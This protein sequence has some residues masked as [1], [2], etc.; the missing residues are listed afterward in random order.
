MVTRTRWWRV[1]LLATVLVA[2][3]TVIWASQRE[4]TGEESPVSSAARTPA[5]T[6]EAA[7]VEPSGVLGAISSLEKRVDQIA[8]VCVDWGA[9]VLF[10]D[11]IGRARFTKSGP[12]VI[13]DSEQIHQWVAEAQESGLSLEE[14]NFTL[15]LPFESLDEAGVKALQKELT[16]R[17]YAGGPQRSKNATR[18]FSVKVA[19]QTKSD[20]GAQTTTFTAVEAG[21]PIVVLWLVIGSM[22]FTVRMGFINIRGF[23]HAILV[24][25]GRYD[26]PGD[27]GEV[28]HFQALTAALSATIGLGNI[29]G[30]AIAVMTGGPGA[31]FWMIMAGFLGMSAK[32]VEC[33]LGQ[34]YR[35]V[36]PD[37]RIM[38]G[39]M[40]YLSRGLKEIKLGGLG[41][42]LGAVFAIICVL[43]SLGGGNAFQ[44]NQSLN[45]VQEQVPF[46]KDYRWVYGLIMAVFVGIVIIGGIR[47][48]AAAAEKIVPS[49]C[50][51]YV[52]ACT[53][54]LIKNGALIPNAIQ[55][56]FEGAFTPQA[57]LGGLLG[58]LVLGFKRAAFSNE[59]GVGSA[60][61][62]H[63]AAK[64][65]YP[66]REGIVALLG[67][68]IDTV[69]V[70]TMTALVIVITGA[71]ENPDYAH[72]AADDNGAGLTS[73]AMGEEISW[74][75]YVLAV[76][77]VLFA[78]STMISWSYYGER[79]WVYLFGD[80]SSLVYRLIFVL[81][82][83]IGSVVT[84]TNILVLSDLM[85]LGMAFPNILGVVLL[86]N[87]VRRDL[88][89]YW[90]RYKA[91]DFEPVS[92]FDRE[93]DGGSTDL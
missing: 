3:A 55:L 12:G 68:F 28:T 17:V 80:G 71:Y 58:V 64:T 87:G 49:M 2:S 48:I 15:V 51:V 92:E 75:P 45:A 78:Y 88:N 29:A 5:D 13:K 81:F 11:G 37:G 69:V 66:V 65:D 40:Y 46:L 4:T 16:D 31:T 39:A 53:W 32:F 7:T 59:A 73:R 43:G 14:A 41:A 82:V 70:C 62:A 1:G 57:G 35:E 67:P 10:W 61:I 20:G 33:T 27:E 60:A 9:A 34:K 25:A 54:I 26:A 74:F 50:I 19:E 77:V 56:I 47:R 42:V 76:S 6:E 72:F 83:V 85:I 23:K 18:S 44:V 30:V 86:S 38:G 36:R 79:C 52:L 24:T 8:G 89:E 84:S 21:F 22:F 91:G 63:S 90:R 93:S